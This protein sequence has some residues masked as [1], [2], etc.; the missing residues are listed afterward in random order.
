MSFLGIGEWKPGVRIETFRSAGSYHHKVSEVGFRS[1]GY[2]MV[3]DAVVNAQ[4]RANEA[5]WD[6]MPEGSGPVVGVL[7]YSAPVK[8]VSVEESRRKWMGK[9]ASLDKGVS[10]KFG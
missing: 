6:D 5:L 7:R 2:N 1:D 8:N 3:S 10:V 9:S 4:K